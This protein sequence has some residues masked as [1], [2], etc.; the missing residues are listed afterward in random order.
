MAKRLEELKDVIE[1]L[2]SGEI[3]TKPK[4]VEYDSVIEKVVGKLKPY[5]YQLGNKINN[6][7]V[8]PPP[9]RWRY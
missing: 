9:N 2:V 3:E 1:K 6:R 8:S 7:W 4:K 5:V